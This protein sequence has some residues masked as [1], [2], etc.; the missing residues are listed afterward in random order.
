MNAAR[1]FFLAML[2][3]LFAMEQA[4]VWAESFLRYC[5]ICEQTVCDDQTAKVE[6]GVILKMGNQIKIIALNG[7]GAVE[8]FTGQDVDNATATVIGELP[9]D[10]AIKFV[11]QEGS[12]KLEGFFMPFRRCAFW[13]AKQ[14]DTQGKPKSD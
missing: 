7:K 13:L 1:I 6:E 8:T 11:C 12:I 10:Q 2:F 5:P 3:P 14:P 4:A 9:V